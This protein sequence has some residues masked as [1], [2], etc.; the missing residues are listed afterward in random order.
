MYI[1]VYSPWKA[2]STMKSLRK[3]STSCDSGSKSLGSLGLSHSRMERDPMSSDSDNISVGVSYLGTRRASLPDGQAET[4]RLM[5][6][7]AQGVSVRSLLQ[8]QRTSSVRLVQRGYLVRGTE[9]CGNGVEEVWG[10]I[11]TST[12]QMLFSV[13]KRARKK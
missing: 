8:T 13:F 10:R 12:V 4:V 11:T 3:H 5:P 7:W 2:I 6:D 1:F 9:R